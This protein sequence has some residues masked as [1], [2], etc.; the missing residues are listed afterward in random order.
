M[1][2]LTNVG[3]FPINR[4]NYLQLDNGIYSEKIVYS[5][6][7]HPALNDKRTI[8]CKKFDNCAELEQIVN[9]DIYSVSRDG[10]KTIQLKSGKIVSAPAGS[11]IKI[12]K[13]GIPYE[14]AGKD[15]IKAN[16]K[17]LKI[18]LKTLQ[19]IEAFYKKAKGE[20][21]YA[22]AIETCKSAI[23]NLKWNRIWLEF[24]LI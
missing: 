2:Q 13:A 4:N 17:M 18:N 5:N 7:E 12:T 6:A 8:T 14:F 22:R 19:D 10:N 11:I 24:K 3:G 20:E 21:A 1:E 16:I 23:S 15:E 9:G